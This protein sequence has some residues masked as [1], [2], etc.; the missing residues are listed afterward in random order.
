MTTLT[1]DI[2]LLL[3]G[4]N[5]GLLATPCLWGGGAILLRSVHVD[6]IRELLCRSPYHGPYPVE[7]TP[8]P[9]EVR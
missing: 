3:Q 5:V 9:R 6:N 7:K 2:K 8:S 1:G 4:Y